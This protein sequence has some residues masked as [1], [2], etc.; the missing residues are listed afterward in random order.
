[1]PGETQIKLEIANKVGAYLPYWRIGITADPDSRRQEHGNPT[2]WHYW[3]AESEDSAR[4]IEK[5]F[6]DKGMKGDTRGESTPYYV[7]IFLEE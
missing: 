2:L 6:L 3:N 7:Y 5:Y 1:M 4:N